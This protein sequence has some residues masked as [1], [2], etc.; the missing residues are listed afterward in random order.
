MN[1]TLISIDKYQSMSGRG[2]AC[3]SAPVLHLRDILI[4][5]WKAH[6]YIRFHLRLHIYNMV[7]EFYE[8]NRKRKLVCPFH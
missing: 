4:G 2:V 8:N 7:D 5:G 1:N 3:P 6:L